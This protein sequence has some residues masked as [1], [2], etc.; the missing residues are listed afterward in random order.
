MLDVFKQDA[1]S[2]ATLTDAINKAPY[3][4]GRIGAM[5]LFTE[6]GIT[7]DKAVVE[8]IDGRLTLIATTPRGGPG[9]VQPA[10]RR[11]AR[12]F[13]VPHLERDGKVNA[14][15]LLGVRA[16]GSD[17]ALE[18]VQAVIDQELAD[19]RAAHEVTLEYHRIGAIKG[20]ILDADGV[21]VVYDLFDEF[22]VSQHEVD[23]DV[24]SGADDL[25]GQIIAIQRLIEDEMGAEPVS[26]FHAF[27]G[28]AFFDA[29]VGSEAV[30]D[31][32][33][34]QEGQKMRD[35][36]RRG[37]LFGGVVWEEYRG[38]VGGVDFIDPFEAHVFPLGSGIFKTYFA[39][40]D[41]LET[42]G[43]LGKPMY[44]KLIPNDRNTHVLVHSQSN[45][46][47]MNTRPRAV[48][49]VTLTT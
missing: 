15:Q 18:T 30:K 9:S 5:G 28:S 49:K 26:G 24:S 6:R 2:I 7:S 11:T 38:S 19:L 36:L 43:T 27:T 33:R 23:L 44:S 22:G 13:Q 35:D 40:A 46:L 1:F 8:M 37:F 45:P 31:T 42:V 47:A 17:N 34:A 29:L 21:E 48:V 14:D 16:F 41:F 12:V 3:K 25:R 4:P 10:R 20:T 32:L 39:P